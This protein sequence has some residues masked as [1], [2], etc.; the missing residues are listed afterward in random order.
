MLDPN[1]QL[2]DF[3]KAG[4]TLHSNV[5]SYVKRSTD[6]E[7]LAQVLAGQFCY[8]LTPR[9]MGKSSLMIRT[10]ER[11]RAEGVR[12]SIVDLSGLGTH[13]LTANQWYL[14][15]IRKLTS[16]LALRL[17]AG[18]WWQEQGQIG[19]VQRF[20]DFLCDVVLAQIPERIAIFVDEIDSTLSLAFTDD[21]FAAIRVIFN[22]R[23]NHPEY[24][25]LT[26][27]LLGVVAPTD[28]IKDRNRTP[29]NIGQAIDLREFNRADARV[30]EEG[31][32]RF[33]PGQGA[34]ILD[35]VFYWTAGHPYLTQKLCVA[36]TCGTGYGSATTLVDEQ[37]NDLFLAGDLRKGED[38]LRFVR[39]NIEASPERRALLQVYRRV[40]RGE[41]IPEDRRS[42]LQARLRLIGL[43]SAEGGVLT[44]RNR[45]Y[46]QVFDLKWIRANT[47]VPWGRI[48]TVMSV[49]ISVIAL[50]ATVLVIRAQQEN[51][52]SVEIST[53]EES[54]WR[55]DDPDRR[56]YRLTEICKRRPVEARRFFF[57]DKVDRWTRSALFMGVGESGNRP[58][59]ELLVDCLLPGLEQKLANDPGEAPVADALC[60]ALA[61]IDLADGKEICMRLGRPYGC[62]PH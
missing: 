57:D 51:R 5:P 33:R 35:R 32:E 7:L 31:L 19:P 1:V 27:V 12:V 3:F 50:I 61:R 62:G 10:A 2:Q 41:A 9:Q 8:V 47:P 24:D 58:E 20:T 59:V 42:P 55:N 54:F 15:I 48:A 43:V 21:F 60:C 26:F 13:Q 18:I 16:D 39:S 53:Y 11:L 45:I 25:R 17:D 14:G 34:L 56:A 46:R 6:D 28:L 22:Q 38:N 37:V 4:G 52:I 44:V 49:I 40:Y 36:V 30:L 23:A 29:F